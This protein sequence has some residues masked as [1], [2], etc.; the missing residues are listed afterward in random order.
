MY[1]IAYAL[2]TISKGIYSFLNIEPSHLGTSHS[3]DELRK[4][5]SAS[6][7]GGS[8]DAVES[9]LIDNVFDFADRVAREVMVPRQDM[10]CLFTDD[11]IEENLK[12]IKET[13]H[14]RYPL[15]TEDRDHIIGMVHIRELMNID[16]KDPK[17]SLTQVMREMEVVPES[18][19]IAKILQLMQ[20]KHVQ[21]AVVADEYGGTA[22][23]VTMEDL[24]EEIVG[25]IQDE[26]DADMP[27][28]NKLADGSYVF[29]GLVL[30]DEVSDVLNIKFEE[31]EED[32]IGGY[33]FGLLG[34]QPEVGDKVEAEGYEF[35][36]LA[37]TGFRVL[38]VKVTPKVAGEE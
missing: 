8:I 32:T 29:D 35:E 26:H 6:E 1:P 17:F 13:G 36:V 19:S 15:C 4:L 18:M 5:V 16:E 9:K 30:L 21:M 25:D 10:I 34:R 14:T 20:Q 12:V 7:K 31:P 24:L 28:V 37:S 11:T 2:G 22:G 23:L 33:V 38:R 27:E 3:E